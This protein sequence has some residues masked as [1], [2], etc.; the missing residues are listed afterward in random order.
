M[1]TWMIRAAISQPLRHR[2]ALLAARATRPIL[3]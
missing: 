1:F 2:I 3:K